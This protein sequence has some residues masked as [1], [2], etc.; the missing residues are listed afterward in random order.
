MHRPEVITRQL[1]DMRVTAAFALLRDSRPCCFRSLAALLVTLSLARTKA[2][3]QGLLLCGFLSFAS[4]A[5]SRIHPVFVQAR[6]ED[7]ALCPAFLT[8]MQSTRKQQ[9][10]VGVQV[11]AAGLR[12][13]L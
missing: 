7:A 13:L 11:C 1:S 4:I 5:V 10:D 2:F 9:L 6:P 8:S 3:L 12:R